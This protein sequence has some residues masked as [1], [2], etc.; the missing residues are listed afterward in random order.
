MREFCF[1]LC[2]SPIVVW[3]SGPEPESMQIFAKSLCGNTVTLHV[4]ASDT[5]DKL[6]TKIEDKKGILP[7]QQRLFFEGKQLQDGKTL[8]DYNIKKQSTLD[9]Q[10]P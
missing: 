1:K 10:V 9:L 6:K 5:I 8:S 2:P 3:R 7:C 4:V